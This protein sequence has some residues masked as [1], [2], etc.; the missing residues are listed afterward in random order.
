MS[1]DRA[2]TLRGAL[3]GAG[4]AAIW[5]AQ[6]PVDKAVFGSSFDDIELLGK[7]FTRSRAWPAVGLLLHVQNGALFGAVYANVAP[8]LPLPSWARGPFAA[9]SEHVATW[10]LTLLVDVL[11]PARKEMPKLATSPRA[12]AQATW[13]HLLFGAVLG[14]LERRL[15]AEPVV[16]IPGY[17][18]VI[19][20]NGHG[21]LEHAASSLG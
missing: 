9:L 2:R 19:S 13:R 12:L 11:H 14:E 6:S 4:A 8:R 16:E 20:S 15:N 10:P 21:N 18:H 17:E 3:A 5:A 1:I 7:A